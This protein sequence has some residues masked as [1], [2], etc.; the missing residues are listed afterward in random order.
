MDIQLQIIYQKPAS[1]S[2]AGA[3]GIEFTSPLYSRSD[4]PRRVSPSAESY[5][6]LCAL[7]NSAKNQRPLTRQFIQ[8]PRHRRSVFGTGITIAVMRFGEAETETRS[9][10]S[11]PRISLLRGRRQKGHTYTLQP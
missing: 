6:S 4:A 3:T 8:Q 1:S 2:F 7:P 11:W 10:K 9:Y 5:R